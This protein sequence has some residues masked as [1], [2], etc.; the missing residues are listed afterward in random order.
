MMLDAVGTWIQSAYILSFLLFG[1]A[2]ALTAVLARR[3]AAVRHHVWVVALTVAI[4]AP[5]A[6]EVVPHLNVPLLRLDEVVSGRRSTSVTTAELARPETIGEEHAPSPSR[7]SATTIPALVWLA[8]AVPLLCLRVLRRTR[9][10]RLAAEASAV[11]AQADVRSH[12]RV[13]VPML[14]GFRR[15][16]I[17]LPMSAA[18]WPVDAREAVLAHERA[19]VQRYDH[20]TALVPDVATI[21]YWLNPLAWI[22]AVALER[23]REAACDE[24]VLRAGIKPS[25]YAAALLRVAH[26]LPARRMAASAPSI[27]GG[28]LN[29]RI[30]A[31]LLHGTPNS[32]RVPLSWPATIALIGVCAVFVASVRLVARTP[33]QTLFAE[34]PM[35]AR[36]IAFSGPAGPP[37]PSLARQRSSAATGRTGTYSGSLFDSA[38]IES[39]LAGIDFCCPEYLDAMMQQIRGS[40]VRQ[41]E[42]PGILCVPSRDACR[43]VV[44][45]TIERDGTISKSRVEKPS[46]YQTLNTKILAI[47]RGV[48]KVPPLPAAFPKPTLTVHMRFAAS[49][50]LATPQDFETPSKAVPFS[51]FMRDVEAGKIEEVTI[52]GQKVSG[53]YRAGRET[54]HTYAPAQYEGLADKLDAQGILIRR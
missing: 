8:G 39:A 37:M 16:T 19:H 24:E 4:V 23:E 33:H 6:R 2:W 48:R 14:A 12:A 22:A 29:A 13:S 52:T 41:A 44:R 27:G 17:L 43:G 40:W 20:V 49:S 45:F 28:R 18:H 15:P 10:S 21:V 32:G 51:D 26:T 3:T 46:G 47:V 35:P 31:V 50:E 5:V 54:F 42:L 34:Q 53:I 7:W 30:R 1:L 36:D 25:V 38:A 9:L 11:D